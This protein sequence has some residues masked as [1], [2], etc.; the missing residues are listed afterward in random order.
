MAL[1]ALGARARG[2]ATRTQ[3]NDL[4]LVTAGG[5]EA[6]VPAA[7]ANDLELLA[8]GIA[9]TRLGGT[10]AH[11]EPVPHTP[12]GGVR[13]HG[14]PVDRPFCERANNVVSC[15]AASRRGRLAG[16]AGRLF[17]AAAFRRCRNGNICGA[18]LALLV[19]PQ[20]LEGH[21]LARGEQDAFPQCTAVYKD[22]LAPAGRCDEAEAALLVPHLHSALLPGP[23]AEAT[24]THKPL[25]QSISRAMEAQRRQRWP[26]CGTAEGRRLW[27]CASCREGRGGSGAP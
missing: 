22:V 14:L 19:V 24:D 18:V 1:A 5:V 3:D 12:A 7:I 13:G 15:G 20:S 25:R 10:R 16:A 6:L 26:C 17:T 23:G 2:G 4:L 27:A 11:G 9:T 8:P 21:D